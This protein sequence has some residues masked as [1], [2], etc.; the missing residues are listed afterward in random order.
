[1]AQ[2]HVVVTVA[3][4]YIADVL[5]VYER[6]NFRVVALKA[7]QGTARASLAA[8]S[9]LAEGASLA[10]HLAATLPAAAQFHASSTLEEALT[11]MHTSFG[12]REVVQ[13]EPHED[14]DEC[15]AVAPL[16]AP[17]TGSH[18][19]FRESFWLQEL[20]RPGAVGSELG[21][22]FCAQLR[23][24]SYVPVLMRPE[25]SAAHHAVEVAAAR[26]F[27]MDEDAKLESGGA[28]GHIDRKFTGYRAGKFRE[29]LEVRATAEGGLYPSPDEFGERLLDLVRKLDS[30]SR[31][32]LGHISHDVGAPGFFESLLDPPLP[33]ASHT[34]ATNGA[35]TNGAATNGAATNGAAKGAER[36]GE[37]EEV[38][39]L[40]H[41]LIRLC[42]YDA[43]TEGVYG[44]DVL[45]EA[46][47]DVGFITLDACASTAGLEA[48]RRADGLWVPIEQAAPPPGAHVLVVMVGDTLGRST[49]NYYAPCKHRVVAPAEGERIGLP[50]LFRGRSDAVLNTIPARQA[51]ATS[52]RAV[53]L[54]EM[55]TTTIKELPAFDSAKII[56]KN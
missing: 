25:E 55:E 8:P 41:P 22:R 28:Y 16:D 42:K 38:P 24:D 36:E 30:W 1:M 44:T 9:A 3:A 18:N 32:L 29:Q 35:A 37:D 49:A 15:S 45:C 4:P 40:G 20:L 13:W 46:H 56:L 43:G 34:A 2:E 52:G 48:L 12:P 54:A 51:G 6:K 14:P 19:D 50:F 31:G 23:R 21:A 39:T 47:N 7:S 17:L 33:A 5:Q 26:W 53:H 11:L 10:A 27:A